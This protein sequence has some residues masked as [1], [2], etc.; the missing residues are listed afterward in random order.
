MGKAFA[1]RGLAC[2]TIGLLALWCFDALGQGVPKTAVSKGGS[3]AKVSGDLVALHGEYQAFVSRGGNAQQFGSPR[4]L[5]QTKEGFVVV[6]ATASGDATA[7]H[8]D[9]QS[10]GARNLSVFGRMVSGRV[11]I[12]AIPN[13][14]ALG[15]LKFVRPAYARMKTGAVTSQGD[16]AQRS[17]LARA[18]FGVDGTGITIGALSDSFDC[19][20]GAAGDVA[21]GDLPPGIVVLAEEA[22]CVSGTDEGRAMMQIIH[23]VA[24]GASQAFHRGL[25]GQAD[26]ANGI[27][28]LATVAGA[29]VIVDDLSYFAAPFFQDGIIAQAVD[30]VKGMGVSYFSAA[31]NDA[32]RSYESAFRPGEIFADGA[33]PSAPN[34]PH[35]FGGTAHDFDPGPGV[36]VFQRITIPANA[37]FD[38]SLQWDSPFASACVGCPGTANDLD[39]Y[40]F[41]DPPT[42]VLLATT[43]DNLTSGD[44]VEPFDYINGPAAVTRN[45]MI[46]KF[47]GPDPGLIKYVR[48]GG[49]SGITAEFDT[50][51]GTVVGHPNAAGA[52]AV[53]AAFFLE[54]PAFGV[55]PPLLEPYSSAGSVPILFDTSGVRFDVPEVREKPEIVAPDGGNT[56]FFVEDSDEDVDTF[57]NFFGTSAAAPHAAGVAALMLDGDASLSPASVYTALEASTIDMLTPGFD[58][59]S[60]FGL[61]QADVVVKAV[62]PD[63]DTDGVPDVVDNCPLNAN[64]DQKDSDE[65][66]IGNVCDPTVN[67]LGKVATIVGTEGND[68]IIVPA[69]GNHVVQ[70]L[71]GNDTITA[72]LG[73]GLGKYTLCG[74]PG[75]DTLTGG[76]GN[77][78]LDGGSG[79]DRCN[80]GLGSDTAVNCETKRNVP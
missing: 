10:V 1:T 70:G 30:I 42:T 23:D 9:L 76:F 72:V 34:V 7:L 74:G 75:A 52:E 78:A 13:L 66:G 58:F 64:P 49:G 25:D 45:F 39:L 15:T 27:I 16:A 19:Q 26:F 68:F 6:D 44:P 60:G 4:A 31:G 29:K 79:T 28:E 5:V 43:E 77:D 47:A 38:L 21:S 69:L 55:N 12:A 36:D 17:D 2:V 63:T 61:I 67:C 14:D 20:G 22:G 56:T 41:D 40:F 3:M 53:G 80:G 71:G 37:S 54:T 48:F 18:S 33:F 65:D 59:D 46:V 62:L 57:P 8:A 11:P 51:S 35:F 24:P 73:L 32:R 50:A